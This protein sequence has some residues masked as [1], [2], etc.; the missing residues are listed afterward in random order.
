MDQLVEFMVSRP[1]RLL[2]IGAAA[3]LIAAG[4]GS[5]RKALAVVGLISLL[6]GMLDV[7]PIAL[8]FGLPIRGN[9]L[10]REL[11]VLVDEPLLPQA[12]MLR[13]NGLAE[14]RH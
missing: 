9:I 10:R 4:L 5:R 1:G 6:G 3:A 7:A 11:G 2:R 13:Q 8:L 14:L 12:A